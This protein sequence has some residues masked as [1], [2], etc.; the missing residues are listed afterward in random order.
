MGYPLYNNYTLFRALSEPVRIE[1]EVSHRDLNELEFERNHLLRVLNQF[2]VFAFILHD[3]ESH[4]EFDVFL[5]NAFCE[6][7]TMTGERLLFFAL[8]N[9]GREWLARREQF[10]FH[11]RVR[12]FEYRAADLRVK[13]LFTSDPSASAYALSWALGI[14]PDQLPVM[15]VTN[16]LRDRSYLCTST[17]VYTLRDQLNYLREVSQRKVYDNLELSNQLMNIHGFED[18]REYHQ[19]LDIPYLDSSLA[20]T[21]SNVLSFIYTA[22]DN[23]EGGNRL[24]RYRVDKVLNDLQKAMKNKKKELTESETAISD[25][26]TIGI[27]IGYL[28]SILTGGHFHQNNLL[29]IDRRFLEKDSW[30]MIT[31]AINVREYLSGLGMHRPGF[32][33]DFSSAAICLAKF[34]E[35]EVNLSFVH[36]IRRYLGVHLPMYF[37]RYEPNLNA[38]YVPDNMNYPDPLPVDF[39]RG[40][41]G[42]WRPPSLGQSRVCVDSISRKEVFETNFHYTRIN[43]V[44]DFINQWVEFKKIRNRASHPPALSYEEVRRMEESISV[45]NRA[46][47]FR[48]MHKMKNN[49]RM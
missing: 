28:I 35:R 33:P 29:G 45:M 19:T 3:P 7:D 15:L 12:Q 47:I 18:L 23:H 37:D 1:G 22:G 31:T 24:A 41:T 38:M 11:R 32:E 48:S 25:I 46:D 36:W 16:N 5:D 43:V 39:N 44:R 27:Q 14:P 40:N 4:P 42:Y 9:P 49:F 10:P 20:D 2:N 21:L 34:F 30:R 8:V 6:L 13:P 26:E 17:S